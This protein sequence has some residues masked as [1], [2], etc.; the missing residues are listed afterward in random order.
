ML[1]AILVVALVL[2]LPGL[3][4]SLW[5]DE[6][7]STR[8]S[9]ATPEL[10]VRTIAGDVHPPFYLIVMFAWIHVFG[11]SEISV[12]LLPLASGLVTIV[13]AA[14][15]AQACAGPIAGT[16]AALVLAL[17]PVHIWYSQEARHYSLLLTLMLACVWSYRRIRE[18]DAA[19]WYV[20]YAVL[21]VCFVFTHYY[22]LVYTAVLTALAL[23]HPRM[24]ARMAVI[25]LGAAALLALYL[26]VRARLWGL[27]TEAGSL[28]TFGLADLWRLPFEWF[29]TG[30]AFGPASGRDGVEQGAILAV[31]LVFLALVVLG[32]LRAGW[33]LAVLF[34]VLPLALL[35]L[36]ALG[37]RGFYVERGAL[38]A[39]PFFA[40][41]TGIG[42][43]ALR[44]AALRTAG[45]AFIAAFGAVVLA[46][47]YAQPDVRTVY[48]PNP[49]WRTIG[50]VLAVER[51]RAGRPVIVVSMSPALELS[52]YASLDLTHYT[53]PRDARAGARDASRGR[54][55]VLPRPDAAL[56]RDIMARERVNVLFVAHNEYWLGTDP[57]NHVI[58]ASRELIRVVE[59]DPSLAVEPA[60]TGRGIRLFRVG[61]AASRDGR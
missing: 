20:A 7:W 15:L 12:R 16:T 41:A 6:M 32:L 2:R 44:P 33:R 61:R 59:A 21:T 22:A 53:A 9:L 43:A 51:E 31:Q 4:E 36:G 50:G 19:R 10:V 58:E 46:R 30:G 1:A 23:R 28:R 18:T 17:S 34:L 3:G 39:L 35:V 24:R 29:L 11:D 25:G 57:P 38:T 8:V 52:Y 26:V 48:K 55:Y 56:V 27:A 45:Q 13:L 54:V 49:D 47:Y 60:G 42:V 40:I 14:R 37:R 5:Y